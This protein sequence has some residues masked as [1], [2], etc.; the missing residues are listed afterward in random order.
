[1]AQEM[2]KFGTPFRI[3]TLVTPKNAQFYNLCTLSMT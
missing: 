3:K 2:Q 1:M